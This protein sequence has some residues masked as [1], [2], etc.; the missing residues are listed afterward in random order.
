MCVKP[1]TDEMGRPVT[2]PA[3]QEFVLKPEDFGH[4]EQQWWKRLEQYYM[5]S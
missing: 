1:D 2:D 4:W 5:I 3:Y